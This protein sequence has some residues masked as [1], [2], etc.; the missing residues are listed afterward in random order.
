M[1]PKYF[2]V[3]AMQQGLMQ[4]GLFLWYNWTRT[5]PSM[6]L[7]LPSKSPSL[8]TLIEE[9]WRSHTWIIVHTLVLHSVKV[10]QSWYHSYKSR[11]GGTYLL[12]HPRGTDA[13]GPS[14]RSLPPLRCYPQQPEASAPTVPTKINKHIIICSTS[15]DCFYKLLEESIM[16]KQMHLLQ[17]SDWMVNNLKNKCLNGSHYTL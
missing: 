11:W 1:T 7:S 2:V 13:L 8:G 17:L 14:C 3:C 6:H 5:I 10:V 9:E 15:I 16:T 12:P 4:Q